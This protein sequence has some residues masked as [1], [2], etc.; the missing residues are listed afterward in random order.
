[1]GFPGAHN[2]RRRPQGLGVARDV[3]APRIG[4]LASPTE[5]RTAGQNGDCQT[6][7]G[8]AERHVGCA[9]G[10]QARPPSGGLGHAANRCSG[11][12]RS[13]KKGLRYCGRRSLPSPLARGIERWSPHAESACCSFRAS[14]PSRRSHSRIPGRHASDSR[15][16]IRTG[17]PVGSSARPPVRRT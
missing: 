15:S 16:L 11:A 10:R 7:S 9:R 2:V 3:S 4:D 14:P 13:T 12:P 1:M 5:C 17:Y 6:P 8:S